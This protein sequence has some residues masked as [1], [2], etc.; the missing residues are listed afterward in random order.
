MSQEGNELHT[1][2]M[3]DDELVRK[4]V[5]VGA[6]HLFVPLFIICVGLMCVKECREDKVT[7]LSMGI[8]A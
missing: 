4:M 8:R 7:Q 5:F 3:Y 6:K 2:T 1:H